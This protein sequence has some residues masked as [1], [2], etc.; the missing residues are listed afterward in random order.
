MAKYNELLVGRYNRFVQKLL[1][2]KGPA[3][4][5]SLNPELQVVLATFHG[6]ENRYLEG[7]DRFAVGVTVAANAGQISQF[8][9]RNP[10]ASNVMAVLEVITIGIS[11]T[12]LV[13]LRFSRVITADDATLFGSYPALDSRSSRVT[14]TLVLS[15]DNTGVSPLGLNVAAR[16][17]IAG[18]TTFALINDESQEY[19]CLPGMT[20]DIAAPINTSLFLTATWRERLLEES[21][22]A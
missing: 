17:N 9:F 2:M 16:I 1:S 19:P 15:Q 3:S 6:V 21:E 11:N 18:A 14:P 13:D 20:Y 5:E 4:L 7:W 22:R 8:R 10:A 12:G